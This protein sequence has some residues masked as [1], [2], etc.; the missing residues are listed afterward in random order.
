MRLARTPDDGPAQDWAGRAADAAA[1][2]ARRTV[3][4]VRVHSPGGWASMSLGV[5][6]PY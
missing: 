6:R 2:E 3:S 4:P 5:G 1:A